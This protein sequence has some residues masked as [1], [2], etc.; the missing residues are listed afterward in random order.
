M[1]TLRRLT[2]LGWFALVALGIV[3]LFAACWLAQRVAMADERPSLEL[4]AYPAILAGPGHVLLSAKLSG[5]ADIERFWC[6][7]IT[8]EF[9][10][11][12]KSKQVSDCGPYDGQSVQ[13]RWSALAHA[14]QIRSV[15]RN[16]GDALIE[17]LGAAIVKTHVAVEGPQNTVH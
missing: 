1:K 11:G 16:M 17:R 7:D 4:R 12:C 2:P 10:D 3:L 14:Y 15:D 6:P 9:G 8:W 5:A 13:R